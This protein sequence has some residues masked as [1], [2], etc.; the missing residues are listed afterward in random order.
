MEEVLDKVVSNTAPTADD[1]KA[2]KKAEEEDILSI[3]S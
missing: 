3:T 1:I 2:K